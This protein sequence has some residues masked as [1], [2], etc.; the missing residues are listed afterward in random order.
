MPFW[1]GW[2]VYML[3]SVDEWWLKR[4]WFANCV[5]QKRRKPGDLQEIA[6]PPRRLSA[7][8]E[9]HTSVCGSVYE[10]DM[11]F[12]FKWILVILGTVQP[13]TGNWANLNYL[14]TDV[15]CTIWPNYDCY[16]TPQKNTIM[17]MNY[18]SWSPGFTNPALDVVL[19]KVEG[20][21]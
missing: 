5:C 4:S 20:G 1:E 16:L 12:D 10:Q 9:K 17:R 13:C 15:K 14:V 11:R 18:T 21:R 3:F 8:K 7:H 6:L 2:C 19:P